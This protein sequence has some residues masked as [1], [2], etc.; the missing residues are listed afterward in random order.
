VISTQ[1]PLWSSP[2]ATPF[3]PQFA[4]FQIAPG[5]VV[6][7][8]QST[9]RRRKI[10]ASTGSICGAGETL[11]QFILIGL[12]MLVHIEENKR[13]KSCAFLMDFKARGQ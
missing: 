9:E 2:L 1:L 7:E 13:D 4:H 12:W 5:R 6:S 8:F 10:K 3:L 11:A